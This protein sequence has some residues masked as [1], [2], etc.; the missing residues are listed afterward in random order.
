MLWKES[1]TKEELA[2][3]KDYCHIGA[4]EPFHWGVIRSG[5]AGASGLFVMQMQDVLELG[6]DCR[7]NTPG[8]PMGN[9]RW[10]M[11][12]GDASAK[13][14][15]W[16][17]KMTELYRRIPESERLEEEL[18][19]NSILWLSDAE[20]AFREEPGCVPVTARLKCF[21]GAERQYTLYVPPVDDD[22]KRLLV[23]EY[24]TDSAYNMLSMVS[25]SSL[26]LYVPEGN[27][28]VAALVSEACGGFFD[29]ACPL[30]RVIR[31]ARRLCAV[32]GLPEFE[33][34]VEEGSAPDGGAAAPVYKSSLAEK[35][36]RAVER[37]GKGFY[38]GIDIGGTGIKLGIVNENNELIYKE[39]FPT[40]KALG[41]ETVMNDIIEHVRP[42]IE[43]Y[44]PVCIG[45]GCP[46][47]KD[48]DNVSILSAGNIPFKN[49]PIVQ[50]LKD[51][52][53]LEVY[54]ENDGN[55]ALIGEWLVG[56]GKGQH[57][58]VMVTI[59]TGI[60][61]GCIVGDKVLRGLH[62]DAGELGHF[63]IDPSGEKCPCGQYG[64]FEKFASATA[65]I[66]QTKKAVEENPD[67]LLASAASE[68]GLD[69]TNG[70]YAIN[71]AKPAAAKG[72][73][74]R[75]LYLSSTMGPS[76]RVN[77]LKF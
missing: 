7:M 5:M 12:A 9:W 71:K 65:L 1:L 27:E 33:L 11:R 20:R 13:L 44:S 22:E 72:T 6:A 41:S 23:S 34:R 10:R 39:S 35:L 76:V 18:K 60:G 37:S 54:L 42:M 61:G 17:R 19:K 4:K 43:E 53:G 16:L 49:L 38:C 29:A 77:P 55:C 69:G 26:T 57:D 24:L 47:D 8:S 56:S 63:V 46:G 32:Y 59:G 14:A 70:W 21:D 52:F 67:S 48:D 58:M 51:A 68:N 50:I 2:Y 64:C 40:R 15:A 73:Y 66:N 75:S 36:L 31:V 28:D 25:G 3:V 62:N 30:N 45:V 74:V